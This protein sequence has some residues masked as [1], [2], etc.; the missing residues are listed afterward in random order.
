MTAKVLKLPLH[1]RPSYK[2]LAQHLARDTGCVVTVN[3]I[4]NIRRKRDEILEQGVFML[5]GADIEFARRFGVHEPSRELLR[6]II[7]PGSRA[8][9]QFADIWD[10]RITAPALRLVWQRDEDDDDD[11]ENDR[12]APLRAAMP[13]P[14][15]AG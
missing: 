11:E 12:R 15:G 4:E 6:S 8:E 13:D 2:D 9:R 5:A 1:E 3:T 10:K 7:A 14:E